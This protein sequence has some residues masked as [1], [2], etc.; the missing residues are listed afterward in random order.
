MIIDWQHHLQSE[1]IY[2]KVGGKP[3]KPIIKDGKVGL[4]Q[5]PESYQVDKH[6][7]FMDSAGID[8]AVLSSTLDSVEECKIVDDL[9]I[10]LMKEYPKRFAGLPPC[11]PTRSEAALKELER[12]LKL[13]LK[14]VVISPQNDGEPLDSR[15][16][17]PFYKKIIQ[18]NVPIFVHI[19]NIPIGYPAMDASYNLNVTMTRE[20]DVAAN[21]ARLIL[22]G[23]LVEFPDLKIV[24]AH[25]GGGISVLLKRIERY[26]GK[27]GE[28]FWTELGGK[29]PFGEPYK[30]NFEKYFNKIYFDMA[31]Y[32]EGVSGMNVVKCALTT[33]NPQQLLFGTDYPYEFTRVPEM[34]NKY[35]ENIKK[36]DLPPATING[37]L[38]DTAAKLLG[39]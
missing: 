17:W 36:L 7:E 8:M 24:M 31:G 27:Y 11:I 3:G 6:L 13:G 9:Y 25:M 15:K 2:K 16:L 26:V 34:A 20:F 4:H 5:F 19:T 38:G 1:E 29:P 28:A 39:I 18:F 35:I 21:A 30:E 22:G 23:V 37:I 10:K 12:G 14:G 33:I 32:E